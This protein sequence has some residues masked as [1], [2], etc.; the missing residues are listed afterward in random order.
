MS[1]SLE[2]I[3]ERILYLRE[4][5]PVYKEILD[6]YEK[7]VE[8]QESIKPILEVGPLNIRKDLIGMHLKEGFPLIDREEFPIDIPSSI[9]LFESLCRVGEDSTN[10]TRENV[11]SIELAI[12]RGSLDPEELLKR[13]S[14]ETYLRET[15]EDLD[16]D[17]EVLGFF[18]HMS[19]QP[20]INFNIVKLQSE[21]DLKNWTK[22]YCPVCGSLPQISELRGE[23][24]RYYLC[25]FC[26]FKWRGERLK[27]PFC[28][29]SDHNS[30]HYFYA[31][32]EEAYRVDLCNR[33]KQYIKTVDSRKLDFEP[34]LILEDL[35][36]LHLDI[37]AVQEGF[38]RPVPNPWGP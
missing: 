9:K 33:C 27:C 17:E 1:D 30:L 18:M 19:I 15:A 3:K 28:E 2:K 13:H 25:S 14:D 5:R 22:G 16:I 38:K 36:T 32:D 35:T 11:L 10:K 31:E 7:V 20:S 4:K 34:D 6:F 26:G 24:Q 21:I 23:G 29:N 8:K 12:R 37:T